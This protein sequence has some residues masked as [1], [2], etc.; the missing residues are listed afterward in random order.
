[1]RITTGDP[2]L[3]R[4]LLAIAG[5]VTQAVAFEVTQENTDVS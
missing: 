1:M 5:A 4:D 2:R 3:T